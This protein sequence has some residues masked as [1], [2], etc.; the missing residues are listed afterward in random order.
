MSVISEKRPRFT[1]EEAAELALSLYGVTGT[2]SP[3]PSERDQNFRLTADNEEVF[4]LKISGAGEKRGILE[5]QHDALDHLAGR[6]DE[7]EWPRVCRTKDDSG[8]TRI[9]GRNGLRHLVRMLTYID[10][11]P[12]CD[13]KP[14]SP[15]L[16]R[17]LGVFL[18]RLTRALADFSHVEKQPD[19]IW[20]MDN[21]PEVV[22]RFADLIPDSG[23]R[24]LVTGFCEAYES[25]VGPHLAS[26]PRQVIHNDA[27]DQNVLVRLAHP[28]DP[29]SS[30]HRIAGLIDFGDMAQSCALYEPAVAAAYVMLGK[31]EPLSAAAHV[32]AGYHA[33]HPLT[34]LDLKLLYHCAV[35]RLCMSVAISAHQQVAEPENTYL[36]VSEKNAWDLLKKLEG[37]SPSFVEYLFRDACELPPCPQTPGIEAYLASKRGSFAPVM[38]PDV[39]LSTA[40]AFDLSVGSPDRALLGGSVNADEL[41]AD[42]FRKMENAKAE[43][44][45]GRYNEARQV[46][47]ADQFMLD[48]DEMPERRT[49]H[50]GMDV[51]LPAG[52]PVYA[53]LEGKVH[54]FRNNTQPL[55]YGP[56]II[57][58]H[59][60]EVTDGSAGSAQALYT[61][62]GHLSVESLT[63]LYE[64]K[65]IEK[66]ERFASLG[67]PTVNGGW[68]PHLHFQI[69][70]DML[71]NAGDFPGVGGPSQRNVWLSLSPDPNVILGVPAEVF[72]REQRTTREILASRRHHIGR[73][74]SI[75]YRRPLKIVRGHM[76]YLYDD[77]G[78]A[79]LDAVNN[80]PHVGH[81]HPEVV[82]AAQRQMTVLNTNTRYLHDNLVD[83]AE[84]LCTKLPDPLSVCFFVNSGSEAN[85][86]ALRLARSHTGQRD[87]LIL[88]GAYHGNLT[89]LIDISP[90]KFD[91]PGGDGAPSHVHKT[92]LPDPYRGP[93]KGYSPE[94]GAWYA[95][96]VRE[97]IDSLAEHDRGLSAF[98]AESLPGCGGQIV[99]PDGYFRSVFHQ[100]REA[101]G[102]CIADEVQ[103]G[104]G[105][106][107]SH[108]WG[109]E[110][111]DA[112]PDIVTLGKPIGNGHPLGAV[113]T[114]PEIAGA[115]DNGMEY[116]NTFGGNPVS[117]AIGLAVLDVIEKEGL[118]ANALE[119]GGYLMEGLRALAP[120]HPI[121]GDVRG[122]GLYVGVELV[123]DRD[124]L[125]PGG[126]QASYVANRMRDHGVLISTDGPLHNV[127]KIK[128]PLVFTRE[129]ADYLLHC[130]GK[131]LK[132][133][134][135]RNRSRS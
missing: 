118:Q 9:D 7:T 34:D 30:E 129:N 41:A 15:G 100:V 54:S 105:R 33:E 82:R 125:E 20:N 89:S 22:H 38:G 115:F 93:Y 113:V 3:L 131:V 123:L 135:L 114:T 58:E 27:N 26:L 16:L 10:G 70:T 11:W 109:F 97:R 64:G 42:V 13:V 57:L 92:P 73:S 66:G 127:L 4:V 49:I 130:L 28:D 25:A 46:Y 95:E 5:L 75:S 53:P 101:G 117:C 69:V 55:D 132:E 110:T 62:Y 52:S 134:Y 45:I 35:M 124:T 84:R 44:G 108:F 104:F 76:Q 31:S 78:R 63:G 96:H 112:V 79:F 83:Y 128:P 94:T 86:L 48:S 56:C 65:Q 107:G 126:H 122:M 80:V 91:G 121:I 37:T 51:F 18:A 47:T 90:Y 71:G 111:Q 72:P 59:T 14:H 67:D 12:L 77:E 98:I 60:A 81:S 39:D 6:F 50:L 40:V 88:D 133:D 23:R 85:D 32:V 19:L 43:A 102:V 99:L 119:V 120:D 61:L 2:L 1:P 116:F 68:P 21:G 87:L 24:R 74:L 36:S 17:D 29:A 103:V 106:V 8:I